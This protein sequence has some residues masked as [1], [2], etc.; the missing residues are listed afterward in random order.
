MKDR[1]TDADENRNSM[2]IKIAAKKVIST[3]QA[4]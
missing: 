1:Q 4:S 2:P 3:S